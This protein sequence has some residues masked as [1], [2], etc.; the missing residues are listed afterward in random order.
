MRYISLVRHGIIRHSQTTLKMKI[1]K[2]LIFSSLYDGQQAQMENYDREVRMCTHSTAYV[3]PDNFQYDLKNLF[4]TA[5]TCPDETTMKLNYGQV[6]NWINGNWFRT[7]PGKFEFGSDKYMNMADPL[8]LWQRMS[9]KNGEVTYKSDFQY[10]SHHVN[11]EKA[12]YI[13]YPEMGTWGNPEYADF[14]VDPQSEKLGEWISTDPDFVSDNNY[15]SYF[16]IGGG[17][18]ASGETYFIWKI[19]PVTLKGVRK[20]NL[21]ELFPETLFKNNKRTRCAS[22]ATHLA[23]YHYD[24]E[25]DEFIGSFVCMTDNPIVPAI[26]YVMYTIPN[27]GTTLKS[28]HLESESAEDVWSR[29]IIIGEVDGKHNAPA[30]LDYKQE[31]FHD[32]AVTKNHIVI[33]TTNIQIDY[34]EMP[35]LMITRTPMAFG[36][37]FNPTENGTWYIF[38]RHVNRAPQ[39]F[40]SDPFFATHVINAYEDETTVNNYTQIYIEGIIL[41]SRHDRCKNICL[42]DQQHI[43]VKYLLIT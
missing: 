13:M 1:F 42:A 26:R 6:P 7:G 4:H 12:G 18:Y 35:R 27:A 20:I 14:E 38:N 8:A 22:V 43:G 34:M 5:Q 31:Y 24:V 23:H 36:A 10:G 41:T 40:K 2:F 21:M 28:N 15:V 11:N 32:F 29:G 39:E 33:G 3:G 17:L 37:G 30:H 25:T 19:D 16:T 9:F